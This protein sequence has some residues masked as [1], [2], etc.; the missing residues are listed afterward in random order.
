M[1]LLRNSNQKDW[2]YS[3][4]NLY[5]AKILLCAKPWEADFTLLKK[6]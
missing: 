5:N 3:T 2:Q 6:M 4:G 1:S